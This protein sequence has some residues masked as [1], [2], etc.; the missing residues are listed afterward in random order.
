M[1]PAL[2]NVEAYDRWAERYP[3]LPHNALM[4]AE[5]QAMLDLWPEV[6]G[7]CALD[8][9]CGTGRYARL[10]QARGAAC[11]IA[12]DLSPGMLQHAQTVKRV[13]ADM[14]QLPFADGAF[15]VIVSGLA[16]GHAP[17]LEGWMAEAARVL[18]PGGRLLLSDFHPDAAR[19]GMR[20][21]FTDAAGQRH[22]LLHGLYDEAAHRAAAAAAGLQVQALREARVGVDLVAPGNEPHWQGLAVVLALRL[23][24]T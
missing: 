6:D 24:K 16:V 18:A 11:V 9:G 4:Q 17:S 7:L 23:C 10:L 21:S 20:R 2:A 13:R 8:L 5:Q 19:A 22:D 14:M 1:R 15:D 12:M 3:P